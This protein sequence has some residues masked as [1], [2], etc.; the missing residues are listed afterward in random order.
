MI[1][2]KNINGLN[3]IINKN[4]ELMLAIHSIF[5][6]H[7]PEYI[8]EFDF[9]EIPPISY[10]D[11]LDKVINSIEHQELINDLIEFKD[12]SECFEIALA[13]NENYEL[14]NNANLNKI[15]ESLG[16][17]NLFEFVNR[18]KMYAQKINWDNFYK[19]HQEF[20][21][22]LYSQFC[23]FPKNLDLNDLKRFYG[24]TKFKYNFIPS[25]LMNGGF[26]IR[27][28]D[29]NIYYIKGIQ[30]WDEKNGFYLD[31]IFL[32]EC[33][34]H[35]FS[36]SYI[37]PLIDK[38]YNKFKNVDIIYKMSK[39]NNLANC[40][41]NKKILLYEYFVRTNA[42]ILTLKYYPNYLIDEWDLKHGF[43]LL[44]KLVKYTIDNINNYKNY[45]D[46]LANDLICFINNDLI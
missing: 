43:E 5:L 1:E 25:I 15:Y 28:L 46:F 8:E 27:S 40:Y 23:E 41:D 30:W 21:I 6:K 45:E 18:F 22:Q 9:I 13:L 24:D 4:L 44:N 37:N 12:Q 11:E 39:K 38:Y 42:Y 16:K 20:Y 33:L 7:H 36:H 14:D 31:N 19:S 2:I 26:G 29:N 34:F 17:V 35:E 10:I 32:L 3:I